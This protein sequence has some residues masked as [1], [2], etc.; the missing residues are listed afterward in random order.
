MH[1]AVYGMFIPPSAETIRY[2]SP[3][4]LQR[5][6]D[7]VFSWFDSTNGESRKIR[8]RYL[9]VFLVARYTGARISEV[10]N[11]DDTRDIDFRAGRIRLFTLKAQRKKNEKEP[12]QKIRTVAVPPKVITQIALYHA[13]WPDQRGRSFQLDRANF[14]KKLKAIAGAAGIE[15]DPIFPHALR[16][17]RAM[18]LI[19]ENVPLNAIQ[20][21]LGHTSILT[22][23]MYLQV[24]GRD[25]EQILRE[26]GLI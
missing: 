22:T 12:R 24:S 25:T 11:I 3:E 2:L 14:Y 18:E 13:E 7:A 17:S 10:T 20:Q 5:L 8:G 15:T 26:R 1:K 6:E 21:L 4:N 23:A 16:H 9:L 19:N